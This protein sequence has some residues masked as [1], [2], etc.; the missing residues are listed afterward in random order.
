[1]SA[2]LI[3][4]FT[5]GRVPYHQYLQTKEFVKDVT[6]S[7]QEVQMA[8]SK[9]AR[10]TIATV[11]Q[12]GERQI[13]VLGAVA[14]EVSELRGE[15]RGGFETICYGLKEISQGIDA[16]DATFHW[17]FTEVLTAFGQVNASLEELVHLVKNPA[18]TWAYE[19]FETA[20][21]ALRQRLYPEAVEAL[22]HAINGF[23]PHVGYKLEYRFHY[24]LGIIYL[25]D[26]E[27]TDQAV[28]CLPKA[29]AA[30]LTAARYAKADSPNEAPVAMMA[31]GWAAYC[32]GKMRQALDHTQQAIVLD[33]KNSEAHF[34]LGKINMYLDNVDAGLA[35]LWEAICIHRNYSVKAATDGDFQKHGQRLAEYL[36]GLRLRMVTWGKEEVALAEERIG[37]MR[38]WHSRERAAAESE[39][40]ERLFDSAKQA[41]STGTY[42]GG[43]DAGYR[44]EKSAKLAEKAKAT[45]ISGLHKSLDEQFARAQREHDNY[46]SFAN[47]H[48]PKAFS[49]AKSLLSEAVS[50]RATSVESY[51]RVQ[52]DL[53]RIQAATAAIEEA[54][55]LAQ[56]RARKVSDITAHNGRKVRVPGWLGVVVFF[57]VYGVLIPLNA[58]ILKPVIGS[59]TNTSGN[60]IF[61]LVFGLPLIFAILFGVAF[62]R[63]IA[64]LATHLKRKPV[65]EK[66]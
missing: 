54:I 42:F 43:L 34:Q 37:E 35:C 56:E 12:L 5:Y 48:A 51:T 22:D 64:Q 4:P 46:A 38:E 28:I 40:A 62:P 65:P 19:Q 23:G 13:Q 63:L 44:G 9:S 11:E 16:L 25:G 15:L 30:F 53:A 10:E 50:K 3:S 52:E 31:A 18:Q 6:D 39:E 2:H 66:K 55:S 61:I 57:P 33:P 14:S 59:G 26:T 36:E 27:N 20:R 7:T 45:Q 47:D 60:L 58:L 49:A 24:Y 21:Q 32:Q 29:E 41:L 8:V 1:M 17:G